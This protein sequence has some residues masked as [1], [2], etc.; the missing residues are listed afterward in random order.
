MD[1]NLIVGKGTKYPLDGVLSLPENTLTKVPAVVLVHGSGPADKDETIGPNKPFRDMAKYLPTQGISVLRYDKRSLVYGKQMVK[2]YA[3]KVSVEQETIEDAILAAN[4]L[5]NDPRID[6]N[7]VYIIGHSLGGMLAP[8]IDAEGGN[9]AGIII[10]AGSPRNL[11]DIMLGQSEDMINQLGKILRFVASMQMAGLRK[12]FD[13]I[14]AMTTEQAQKAKIFGKV[15]A[16][17]FKEMNEHPVSAYLSV[18]T[19]PVLILQGEKDFQVS[20]EKDF[21]L[22]KKI[23]AGK[24]NVEFKLYPDLNHMFLKSIYGNIKEYK[25]EYKVAGQVDEGVLEDIAQ[26]IMNR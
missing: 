12:K 24:A 5:K 22:Y 10:W 6:A 25:K 2:E 13:A 7:R 4:I 23:C 26:W 8:R 1:E 18:T 16:W 9:F 21:N 19:K 3:G 14:A 20:V 11:D 15:Y 17:Y